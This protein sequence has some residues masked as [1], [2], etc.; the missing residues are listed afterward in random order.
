MKIIKL[1]SNQTG[2]WSTKGLSIDRRHS[3]RTSI[4]CLTTHFTS[5]G[6][7]VSV[8]DEQPVRTRDIV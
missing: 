2:G 4:T 6:V 3:N 7:F 8:Q 5:F 1:Y